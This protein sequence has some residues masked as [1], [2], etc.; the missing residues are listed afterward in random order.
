[1]NNVTS[2][3]SLP[4]V[5]GCE[6]TPTMSSLEIAQITGKEHGHVM[7]D[8]RTMLDELG[9]DESKFGA[10]YVDAQNRQK[11]C[12]FLPEEEMLTLVT[13]YRTVLRRAIISRWKALEAGTA[14]PM[15]INLAD[16]TALSE[17]LNRLQERVAIQQSQLEEQAPKVDAFERLSAS[18]GSLSIT[19]AAREL[20]MARNTFFKWLED[21]GWIFRARDRSKRPVPYAD[22]R[23]AGFM[24]VVASTTWHGGAEVAV[25]SCYI[26]RKG[27]AELALILGKTLWP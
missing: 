9:I 8:I 2:P 19:D 21:N 16:P 22:K 5:I 20:S 6:T 26:T 11:P 12:Y 17:V 14:K 27:L 18:E 13:G 1:M 24:E 15:P 4:A 10:I 3:T 25:Q 7:R 23:H